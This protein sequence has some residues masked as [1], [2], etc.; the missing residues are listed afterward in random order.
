MPQ[1]HIL[2]LNDTNRAAFDTL[3]R[4]EIDTDECIRL[5]EPTSATVVEDFIEAHK[6]LFLKPQRTIRTKDAVVRLH[7]VDDTVDVTAIHH[8][9]VGTKDYPA[10]VKDARTVVSAEIKDNKLTLGTDPIHELGVLFRS[11]DGKPWSIATTRTIQKIDYIKDLLNHPKIEG[12]D[13]LLGM[14]TYDDAG[15]QTKVL[16][17]YYKFKPPVGVVALPLIIQDYKGDIETLYSAEDFFLDK[18]QPEDELKTHLEGQYGKQINRKLLKPSDLAECEPLVKDKKHFVIY[19]T[20]QAA[21]KNQNISGLFLQTD[22]NDNPVIARDDAT[23]LDKLFKW[24]DTQFASTP[25]VETW[26]E[27]GYKAE[28]TAQGVKVEFSDDS[29]LLDTGTKLSLHGDANEDYLRVMLQHAKE[30]WGGTFKIESGTDADIQ[31]LE[32]LAGKMN[33]RLIKLAPSRPAQHA[34]T[35]PAAAPQ[36]AAA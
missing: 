1:L 21:Y 12:V 20:K 18:F 23:A 25:Y 13:S 16:I 22:A 17:R 26:T 31:V 9:K 27:K 34:S 19:K 35:P 11:D 4:P 24:A 28:T 8:A 5:T 7:S 10:F 15:K 14:H 6:A 30:N 32:R 2:H 36:P 29:Y 3:T 33:V